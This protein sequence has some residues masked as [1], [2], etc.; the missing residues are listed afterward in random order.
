MTRKRTATTLV[1]AVLLALAVPAMAA[2]KVVESKWTPL[3]VTIDAATQDWDDATPILDDASKA[4]YALKN[5]GRNLYVIMVFKNEI[6]MSTLDFS[7]M[8]IYF[9]AGAKKTKDNG[10]LFMKK[11]ITADDLIASLEKKGEALSEERKAEM[12]KQKAYTIFLEETIKPKKAAAAVEPNVKLEPTLFRAMSKG[13]VAV[14]E[15]RIPLSRI[16]QPGGTGTEPGQSVMLGFEWGGMTKEIMRNV[17]A[18][19]A[20]SGSMAR[21]SKGSSDSGF[22]DSSGEGEGGGG[23]F[24]DFNRDPRYKKHAFWIEAK[25]A[26]KGS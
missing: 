23:G 25:L 26:A 7:G 11:Q 16:G 9:A 10:I 5:D 8:K 3:P 20:S 21:Q 18:D 17:M 13:K 12:R 24:S 1:L 15:F 14:Y 6:I 22:S 2:D 4:E 19:R